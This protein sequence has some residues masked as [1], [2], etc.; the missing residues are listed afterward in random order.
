[1]RPAWELVTSLYESLPKQ[2]RGA[3][4]LH[5]SGVPFTLAHAAA[6]LP[7][8]RTRVILPA[9]I[10]GTLAPDFEYFL[11]LAP[12]GSLG[13]TLLGVFVLDLPLAMLVL[14]L[15][16]HVVRFSTIDL[17]PVPLRLRFAAHPIGPLMSGAKSPAW[18]VASILLGISTH[19][20]WDS[21]T[22]PGTWPYRHWQLLRH[23]IH[24]PIAGTI[25]LYKVL[26][27]GSTVFGICVLALWFQR[28]YRKTK[29]GAGPKHL[30]PNRFR[31]LAV[32]VTLAGCGALLRAGMGVHGGQDSLAIFAGEA[33]VTFIA[34][35]WWQL[36]GYGLL[37]R[38]RA[39]YP[40]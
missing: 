8:R 16:D 6:A 29:P 19:I 24:L 40:C 21:F 20:V 25:Q 36:V 38:R 27:H 34:L 23:P 33:V 12:T 30:P 39:I 32:L 11:R 4:G 22:H 28:W 9:L 15:F 35:I 10:V 5:N 1:M 2:V 18:I 14:W 26:Q 31:R 17:M 37:L 7:F 3:A 13:H